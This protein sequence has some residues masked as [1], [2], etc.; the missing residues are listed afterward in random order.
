M[1][2]ANKFVKNTIAVGLH[3]NDQSFSSIEFDFLGDELDAGNEAG[4]L[5]GFTPSKRSMK[6]ERGCWS[7]CS[8][9][10]PW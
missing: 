5:A 10:N 8:M 6:W 4:R 9:L 2:E 7:S 3:D 1:E